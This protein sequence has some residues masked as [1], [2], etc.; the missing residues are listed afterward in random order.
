[1]SGIQNLSN[2]SFLRGSGQLKDGL[3]T[4]HNSRSKPGVSFPISLKFSLFIT[5]EK[6]PVLSVL[7]SRNKADLGGGRHKDN[8]AAD[9]ALKD[10]PVP[11][12]LTMPTPQGRPEPG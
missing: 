1:M 12:F 2:A 10:R 7:H 8:H 5:I 9:L 3:A 11:Q 6:A 4:H